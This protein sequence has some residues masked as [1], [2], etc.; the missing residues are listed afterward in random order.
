MWGYSK[1][2]APTGPG[3]NNDPKHN[4]IAEKEKNQSATVAQSKS[5]VIEMLLW[6]INESMNDCES[7]KTEAKLQRRVS[8]NSFTMWEKEKVKQKMMTSSCC[9]NTLL[10]P[11]KTFFYRT[12]SM[13]PFPAVTLYVVFVVN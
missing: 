6:E 7:K 13:Q 10:N 2:V 5:K 8:Q 3:H 1:T 12:L 11:V 9:F 4:G